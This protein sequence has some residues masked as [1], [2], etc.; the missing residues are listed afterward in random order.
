MTYVITYL[1]LKCSKSLRAKLKSLK[2]YTCLI[3]SKLNIYLGFLLQDCSI[4]LH[5]SMQSVYILPQLRD[6]QFASLRLFLQRLL[7]AT[8]ETAGFQKTWKFQG[9][10]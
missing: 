8:S 10:K 6:L 4:L 7:Q 3:N 1:I 9:K 2:I 5:L